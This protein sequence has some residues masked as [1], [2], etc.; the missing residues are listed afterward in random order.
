MIS[1]VRYCLGCFYFWRH[2]TLFL[3]S[4]SG[5][6]LSKR[7]KINN[8]WPTKDNT[9]SF[10]R[11]KLWFCIISMVSYWIK[12]IFFNFTLIYVIS[13][14]IFSQISL[15]IHDITNI[16]SKKTTPIYPTQQYIYCYPGNSAC[17]VKWGHFV[18]F[19]SIFHRF[20]IENA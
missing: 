6:F 3:T 11:F 17:T 14:V 15:K 10:Y 5:K 9:T 13:E 20:S 2:L 19:L 4:F 7:H 18:W 1:E 12:C 16:W 8:I